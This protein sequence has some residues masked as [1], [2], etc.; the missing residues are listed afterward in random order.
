MGGFKNLRF[1]S[2]GVIMYC[3][4]E[5]FKEIPN[6]LFNKI[7][8][9]CKWNRVLSVQCFYFG[10]L[11]LVVYDY[12]ILFLIYEK[13]LGE[14]SKECRCNYFDQRDIRSQRNF[15]IIC[16]KARR[17]NPKRNCKKS[18]IVR[19]KSSSFNSMPWV[20]KDYNEGVS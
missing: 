2:M 11:E 7:N 13:F 15:E 9:V 20:S 1:V 5:F 18:K 12:L 19:A 14:N 17:N 8:S 10:S 3:R 4:A 6:C 16:F